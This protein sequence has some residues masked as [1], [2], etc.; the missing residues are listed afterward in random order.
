M[1][2]SPEDRSE[3]LYG[4]QASQFDA[5]RGLAEGA[6]EWIA[7]AAVRLLGV[8]PGRVLELGAG[9]GEIGVALARHASFYVALES[10]AGMAERWRERFRR[11]TPTPRAASELVVRDAD[12]EW[13]VAAASV[14]LVF[15]S[16]SAHWL[17]AAHVRDEFLRVSRP[18]A[19]LLLGRVVRSLD[20]PR[21]WLRRELHR[22]LLARARTPKDGPR[23]G[24]EL[25]FEIVRE[26][27][28]TRWI[29]RQSVLEWRFDAAPGPILQGWREKPSLAGLELEPDERLQVLDQVAERAR[30]HFGALETALACHEHY[31]LEGVQRVPDGASGEPVL[32]APFPIRLASRF[33]PI[34]GPKPRQPPGTS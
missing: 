22:T 8:S 3:R 7:R 10:S 19:C 29:P 31:A 9:T 33:G 32:G 2:S 20:H 18:G 30:E 12:L 24:S 16:R 1:A 15:A 34:A 14:D 5:Q 17:D 23:R 25:L 11:E 21:R 28:E 13:P 27:P 6:P 26:A 4:S